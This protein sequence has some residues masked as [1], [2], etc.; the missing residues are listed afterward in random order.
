MRFN[1][2]ENLISENGLQKLHDKFVIVFGLGGVGSFAAEALVRSGIGHLVVVDYDTVDITNINRQLIALE[3][4]IGE[5]KTQV[6]LNRAKD[7]NPEIEIEV[8]NQKVTEDNV[9]EILK[10]KPDFVLDCID[11]V[12]AKVELAKAC[13]SLGIPIILA[14]GFANKFH[15]EM[16]R[17]SVLKKTSVCPLAKVMRRKF[18]DAGLSMD[19]P[20]VYSE[21][22]PAEVIDKQI[23]GST[24]FCPSSAGLM[25]ASFVINNLIESE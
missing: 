3:S 8:V 5:Y 11:D 13:Q 12:F 18:K 17:L 14:M 10:R 1:R 4:T 16:I 23:L 22:K 19:I 21:E 9:F 6:F 20:V 15:P 7:I 24:A 25:M 2:L